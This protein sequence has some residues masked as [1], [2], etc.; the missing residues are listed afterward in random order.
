MRRVQSN[1]QDVGFTVEWAGR[2]YE[3]GVGRTETW[4]QSRYV[5]TKGKERRTLFHSP[6]NRHMTPHPDSTAIPPI[7]ATAENEIPTKNA[8][9]QSYAGCVSVS[10]LCLQI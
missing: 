4:V 6:I 10:V 9:R 1:G 3:Y 8:R 5:T 7:G 2:E